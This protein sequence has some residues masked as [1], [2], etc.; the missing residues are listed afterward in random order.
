M[1]QR[2]MLTDAWVEENSKG[3]G[4][5]RI[6][7][8]RKFCHIAKTPKHSSCQS[9]F[10]LPSKSVQYAIQQS[11]LNSSVLEG[12]STA[13]LFLIENNEPDVQ[14]ILGNSKCIPTAAGPD[15]RLMEWDH[16]LL[17][18]LFSPRSAWC[19]PPLPVCCPLAHS[20]AGCLCS[21]PFPIPSHAASPLTLIP[22]LWWLSPCAGQLL[23]PASLS[24]PD[25]TYT[26]MRFTVVFWF[27]CLFGVRK[28]ISRK[29]AAVTS[30]LTCPFP[31]GLAAAPARRS[32]A[33]QSPSLPSSGIWSAFKWSRSQPFTARNRCLWEMFACGNV[34]NGSQSKYWKMQNTL[35]KLLAF[36]T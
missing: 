4:I 21:K 11:S 29:I 13:R 27:I 3:K 24:V 26:Q 35:E 1:I 20:R 8:L 15:L 18:E 32:S 19:L 33:Q 23:L 7:L 14:H 36:G 2:Q 34:L 10:L 17:G 31:C 9:Q 25:L 16:E 28:S 30:Y 12:A 22:A 6:H 5:T